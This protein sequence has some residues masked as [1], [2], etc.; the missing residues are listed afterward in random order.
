MVATTSC[1]RS[2]TASHP[3]PPRPKG[4]K[5][6]QNL[7]RREGNLKKKRDERVRYDLK[8]GTAKT[9]L[10]FPCTPGHCRKSPRLR[11][12]PRGLSL[13]LVR[14]DRGR[15]PREEADKVSQPRGDYGL[16]LTHAPAHED[17]DRSG[18]SRGRLRGSHRLSPEI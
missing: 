13:D 14:V 2:T 15:C 6:D 7:H 12:K 4:P 17:N 5:A 3:R 18:Q 1:P 9:P 16:Q 10:K 8:H 11:R